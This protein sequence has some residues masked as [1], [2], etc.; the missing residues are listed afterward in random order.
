MDFIDFATDHSVKLNALKLMM[1][2]R[3]GKPRQ[4]VEVNGGDEPIKFVILT[5]VPEAE[6]KPDGRRTAD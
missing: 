5:G 2:Y 6:K 4:Q 3:F 1:E